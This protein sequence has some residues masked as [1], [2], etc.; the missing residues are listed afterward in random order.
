MIEAKKTRTLNRQQKIGE[1][2]NNLRKVPVSRQKDT[3]VKK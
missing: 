3:L 1:D 2:T